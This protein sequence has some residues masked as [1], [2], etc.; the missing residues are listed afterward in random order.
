MI[1]RRAS[2][3]TGAGS[4][5]PGRQVVS[6]LINPSYAPFTIDPSNHDDGG[7]AAIDPIVPTRNRGLR[8]LLWLDGRRTARQTCRSA[9]SFAPASAGL[10]ALP[11]DFWSSGK[12]FVGTPSGPVWSPID[13]TL[14]IAAL[15]PAKPGVVEWDWYVPSSVATR[16][17][18]LVLTT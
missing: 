2:A 11:A 7:F 8:E 16:T 18:I 6:L 13:P 4:S 14:T 5:S 9:H 15:E 17:C 3:V 12:P 1:A 10:P